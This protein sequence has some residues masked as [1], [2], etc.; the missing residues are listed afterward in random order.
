MKKWAKISRQASI[1]SSALLVAK[2]RVRAFKTLKQWILE[3]RLPGG[4]KLPS[5]QALAASLKVARSA[6][7]SALQQLEDDGLVRPEGKRG[8]I[9]IQSA[10][11]V[12]SVM[13]QTV[14]VLGFETLTIPGYQRSSGWEIYVQ[15]GTLEAIRKA[16]LHAL[17][18][19]G[20][21]MTADQITRLV[22][23]RPRGCIVRSEA[24]QGV[25]GLN[26]LEALKG[27]GVP[28]VV[29]GFSP[30]LVEGFDTVASDHAAGS[31][32]LTRWLIERG[33]RRVLRYWS[34]DQMPAKGGWL[35]Q[36][37][38]G[39]ERAMQEANLP[40]IPAI[41]TAYARSTDPTADHFEISARLAVGNLLEHFQHPQGID[42]I[43]TPS[44]GDTFNVM[45]AIRILGKV[46]GKDVLVAGYD[47]YFR[48][49]T[50]ERH[51][52]TVDPVATV[53]KQNIRAGEEL[54]KLLLAR[55]AGELPPVPQLRL[56][57]PELVVIDP[58]ARP[59]RT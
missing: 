8:R 48:D 20:N 6:I 56:I 42:A 55:V 23:D 25:N 54:L 50:H 39:H 44:D 17:S 58:E 18:L 1:D 31:Y 37:D 36:R 51:N 38:L 45:R 32:K 5:E 11:P 33:C 10:E 34:V 59:P 41:R 14:G 9:V 22:A 13:N 7:R 15:V 40:I 28:T 52:E 16:G 43:L 46:P 27:G 47:N 24:A 35:T 29:R 2:P 26:L 30:E 4:E 57:E 49:L 19:N 12:A 3:G 53:D 21:L